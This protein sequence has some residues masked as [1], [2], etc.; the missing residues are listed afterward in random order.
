VTKKKENNTFLLVGLGNPGKKYEETRHNIGFTFINSIAKKASINIDKSKFSSLCARYESGENYFLLSKPQTFMNESGKAVRE[1][2]NYY[3]IPIDKTIIVFDDLDLNVGQ[4][5]IKRGGG[6]GGH[7][8]IKSIIEELSEDTFIRIRIGIGK[9][10]K[11]TDVDQYV[12]SKFNQN[13]VST[14]KEII[15]ISDE[16]IDDIVF[17]GI[18]FAMNKFNSKI[19]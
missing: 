18:A 12:L 3:K 9:P 1:I 16:I 6:S 15:D 7:N 11:K 14:I 4:I 8:G 19:Q 17:K 5:R 10:V 2:K 13:E